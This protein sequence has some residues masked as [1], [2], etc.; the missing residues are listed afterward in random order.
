[1][2]PAAITGG[3]SF[4][5]KKDD[6]SKPAATGGLF[7]AKKDDKPATTGGFSFGAKTD[8]SKPAAS[9]FSF[10]EKKDDAKPATGG[11]FGAKK[12]D[13]KP[14]ASGFSFAAKKDDAAKPATTGGFS[15]GAKK[16]EET[17]PAAGGL[18]GAKKD[19]ADKPA[20]G[21]F[22]FGAKKDE[23][24]KPASTGFSFGAKPTDK[25][26][27]AKAT[28]APTATASNTSTTTT[29]ATA[30]TSEAQP[31]LKPTKIEPI[32]VSIDNKTVDDLIVKWSKQLTT[33]SKIFDS[34]TDKVKV[35]DQQ[36]VE[37]GDDIT[38]LNQEAVEADALQSKIDQQLLFVENQQDEL[39]KI[40]DNYEQQADI[41]LNNIELNNNSAVGASSLFHAVEGTNKD[42]TS[43]DSN[44]LT[45]TSGSSIT[46]GPSSSLSITDKL[47]EKAYHNAELLD[48]RLD[49][50]GT[51]LSTL[52]SEINS[53]SDVFNKNLINE[54][55]NTKDEN[56]AGK[57]KE[58]NDDNP[59]EEI[60]KLL[61]L[62]LENLKYIEKS[63][64]ELKTKLEK[65]NKTKKINH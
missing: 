62:H 20:T 18:F 38:K 2:K 6:E 5:A 33:T 47:R 32:P 39:E 53:V 49:N 54:L 9:G 44:A 35:W 8:E 55:A 29:A 41:L 48:E 11:L 12:D 58:N 24:A 22:S 3:F 56:S 61:N 34:Y 45:T 25:T 31:N 16:D 19:E 27:D 46:S 43:K 15:F 13:D 52:I 59:I 40:L 1:D 17:K 26:D 7:G 28:T 60:V 57:S 30:T 21:G 65:L 37:S 14:A 42:A 50:L 4:G 36:L 23:P 10:G 63:E 51:N 64:E